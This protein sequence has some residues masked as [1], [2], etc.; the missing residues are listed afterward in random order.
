[1]CVVWVRGGGA[2][3]REAG[4]SKSAWLA[5]KNRFVG[6][7]RRQRQSGCWTLRHKIP[8]KEKE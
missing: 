1:M 5:A 4:F 3:M 2:E 8:E 7:A 6:W